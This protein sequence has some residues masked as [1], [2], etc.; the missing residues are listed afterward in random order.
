MGWPPAGWP[1]KRPEPKE[2]TGETDVL[3]AFRVGAAA[4]EPLRT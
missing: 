3:R 2:L 1:L 4:A